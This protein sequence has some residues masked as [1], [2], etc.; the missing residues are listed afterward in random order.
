MSHALVTIIA[1]LPRERVQEAETRIDALGNPPRDDLRAA[2]D[3][4]EGSSGTHFCSL[5][6]VRSKDLGKAYLAFEFSADGTAGEAI[7]RIARAIGPQLA[8]VFSLTSD[9]R[10]DS[11]IGAYLAAHKISI[12]VGLFDSPGLAFAGTPGLSV[13]RILA[14]RQLARR[15][16]DSLAEQSEGL[17]ALERVNAVRNEISTPLR[18]PRHRWADRQIGL[19]IPRDVSLAGRTAGALARADWWHLDRVQRLGG[20]RA[21]DGLCHIPVGRREIVALLEFGRTRYGPGRTCRCL[22]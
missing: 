1:P 8:T 3:R 22:F 19:V 7:G 4:L 15:A 9:W 11:D 6:A 18:T 10:G 12:G 14:E 13:G 20:A 5:H 21:R 16:A 2:L 17:W